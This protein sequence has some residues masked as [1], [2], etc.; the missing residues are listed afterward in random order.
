LQD[1][2]TNALQHLGPLFAKALIYNISGNAARSE[3]DKLS[4]PLR[5]LVVAGVRSKS[6]L[7]AALRDDTFESDKVTMKDKSVFLQKVVKYVSPS[8]L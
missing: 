1:T 5:K 4:E 8:N 7:D 2:I 6:W 3:L